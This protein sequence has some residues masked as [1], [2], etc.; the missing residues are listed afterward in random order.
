[1]EGL[2]N[3]GLLHVRVNG[4]EWVVP[5]NEYGPVVPDDYIVSFVHFHEHKLASPPHRFLHGLLHHYWIELQHLSPNG[6]QHISTFI[7]LCK[8]YL[9]IELHFKL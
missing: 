7:V 5:G 2:I 3:K 6:I 9:G 4:D 8:G 1:M